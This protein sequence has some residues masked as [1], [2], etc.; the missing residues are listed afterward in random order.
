MAV[1]N[2]CYFSVKYKF[3][4]SSINP[5]MTTT[6][7]VKITTMILSLGYDKA[8]LPPPKVPITEH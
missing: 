1:S 6:K 4:I 5:G 7:L 3:A 8:F 2:S